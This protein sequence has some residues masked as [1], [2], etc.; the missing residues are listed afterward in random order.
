MRGDTGVPEQQRG[1]ACSLFVVVDTRKQSHR[2]AAREQLS[3]HPA[4]A[5]S[6]YLP[7]R[8]PRSRRTRRRTLQERLAL[9][10][11]YASNDL[12]FRCEDGRLVHP[13][14]L[15]CRFGTLVR[16]AKLPHIRLHD[17]RHTWASLGLQANVPVK[18]VSEVLGHASV[19]ITYDT[20]SPVIPGMVEDATQPYRRLVFPR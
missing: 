4:D 5:P 10:P 17:L 3:Y 8:S 16:Q 2:L 18:V 7:K 19:T 13:S 11:D 20:Y 9:G 6:P 12:V 15:S 1:D 14:T